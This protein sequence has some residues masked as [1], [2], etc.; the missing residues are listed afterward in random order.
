[1][2][3]KL[4]GP[5]VALTAPPLP[6]RSVLAPA[7]AAGVTGLLR[8]LPAAA[9]CGP[10]LISLNPHLPGCGCHEWPV[11]ASSPWKR[12][13]CDLAGATPAGPA[14]LPPHPPAAPRPSVLQAGSQQKG[15][16]ALPA[17]PPQPRPEQMACCHPSLQAGEAWRPS[18][19]PGPGEV[20]PPPLSEVVSGSWVPNSLGLC[21]RPMSFSPPTAQQP[22]L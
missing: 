8:P 16:S 20:C 22:R 3:P 4:P 2:S 10:P 15:H 7:E 5:E 12:G 19:K 1:M 13:L 18:W 17:S 21:A 9:C 6:S 11:G 14:R